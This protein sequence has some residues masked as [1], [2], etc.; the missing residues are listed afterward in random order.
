MKNKQASKPV[1]WNDKNLDYE[2]ETRLSLWCRLLTKLLTWNDKNLD[3]EIETENTHI[4]MRFQCLDLKRQEPRLRDWN[5][6]M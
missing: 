1:T 6:S 4:S 3:Y 2:I 5:C